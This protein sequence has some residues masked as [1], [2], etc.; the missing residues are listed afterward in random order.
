MTSEIGVVRTAVR[1]AAAAVRASK[2]RA[3]MRTMVSS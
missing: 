1:L 3:E 2:G